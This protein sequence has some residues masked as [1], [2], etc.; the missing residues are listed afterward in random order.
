[1]LLNRPEGVNSC[2]LTFLSRLLLRPDLAAPRRFSHVPS[3]TSQ[4]L[5]RE[6]LRDQDAVLIVADHSSYDWPWIVVHSSLVVDTR[7]ATRDLTRN[8]E[9]LIRA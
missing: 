1:M 2:R 7:N 6:L 4:P 3:L 9:R 5:S 8:R